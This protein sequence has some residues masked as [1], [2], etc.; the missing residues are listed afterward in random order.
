[1]TQLAISCLEIYLREMNTSVHKQKIY[2]HAFSSFN[3]NYKD[4]SPQTENNSHALHLVN[5]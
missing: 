4:K 3:P 5:E 1:M 2:L